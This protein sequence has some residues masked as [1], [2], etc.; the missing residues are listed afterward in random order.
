MHIDAYRHIFLHLI[1]AAIAILLAACASIGTPSGGPRDETPPEFTGASPA[2]GA[3]GVNH[4][5]SNVHLN[6][7]EIVNVKDAFSTVTISP[8]S[9][10]TPRVS[11]LGKRVNVAFQDS[12]LPNTTYVVDFGSAICDNNE[13]NPLPNFSYTFSTGPTLDTL[14]ISGMVLNAENL[15]PQQKMLVGIHSS[16]ADS[17]F[18][19][20]KFERITR[21]DDRGQ[22]TIRGLKPGSYRVFALAD[23]NNDFRW[24][25]PAEDIAFLDYEVSP[26]AAGMEVS[27]TIYNQF[28]GMPDTVIMRQT[29]GYFPNDLLLQSFNINYKP[30]YLVSSQRTDSTRINLIF[31][32]PTAKL[33]EISFIR[34]SVDIG[35]SWSILEKTP[36]CDTLTYWISNPAL[37]AT[38]TLRIE[39]KYDRNRS[40][41]VWEA[42]IDTLEL[43]IQRPKQIKKDSKKDNAAASDTTL[44]PAS[45]LAIQSPGL[46]VHDVDK[47]RIVEFSAP[48]QFIDSAA[49]RLEM[50]E[51]SI[52]TRLDVPLL[53]ADT[54][55]PRRYAFNAHWKFDHK[56]RIV[57]DTIAATDIYG[58]FNKPI[59]IDF[60][61][62]KENDYRTLQLNIAGIPDS[63]AAIV[64]VLGSGEK[65]VARSKVNNSQVT[66]PYLP[67]GVYYARI[68]IDAN[69]NGIWD[70]GNY[71]LRLQPEQVSYLPSAINLKGS[72]DRYLDWD[73]NSI[74]VDMQKPNAIK[75]NKPEERS[76]LK[77]KNNN[78]E[79]PD[80][81]DI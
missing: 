42:A 71:D 67:K 65:I 76:R 47:P 56:Y 25:N 46:S 70:T 38:D 41:G 57:A 72:M 45:W 4:K 64:E 60:S 22:F 75:K 31:N 40:R 68:F 2:N 1:A 62:H 15:E 39:V 55:N 77:N 54:L 14:R 80:D 33:P 10:S 61:T 24:D 43:I 5:T 51:D 29:T 18:T 69:D 78:S 63:T 17:A 32:S 34:P 79:E 37:V 50:L 36:G 44:Q 9:S 23:I 59:T 19:T 66:F 28:T 30:Q 21:T 3:T 27:D 53:R 13:G 73:I 81:E 7:N 35:K 20:M 6:F 52:W 48:L 58:A 74:A 16:K 49:L 26:Y 8:T 11:S 12:L